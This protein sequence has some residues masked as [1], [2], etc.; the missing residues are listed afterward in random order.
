MK[1]ERETPKTI[2]HHKLGE[3]FLNLIE[4]NYSR[5]VEVDVTDAK[6][7]IV[8]LST[9]PYKWA[10][11]DQVTGQVTTYLKTNWN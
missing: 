4:M 8:V 10:V 3:A 2:L 11:H 7:K 1:D 6:F 5:S 9:Y